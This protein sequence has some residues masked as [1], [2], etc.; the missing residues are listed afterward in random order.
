MAN[1]PRLV[2]NG[3][4][5]TSTGLTR[6]IPNAG[7]RLRRPL[8]IPYNA[9][10]TNDNIVIPGRPTQ[11]QIW[12]RGLGFVTLAGDVAGVEVYRSTNAAI[13]AGFPLVVTFDTEVI[14]EDNFWDAGAPTRITIPEDGWYAINGQAAVDSGGNDVLIL[15]I[16]LNGNVVPRLR[17]DSYPQ[18]PTISVGQVQGI[19]YL[20]LGDYLELFVTLLS[21]NRNL[22]GGDEYTFL[23][24]ARFG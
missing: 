2:W 18:D 12:P 17:Q 11:G 24:V 4:Y 8:P 13:T 6:D 20:E 10:P 1:V 5:V 23:Q 22:Q 9:I 3:P 15:E 19:V 7:A 14:D 21:T 16:R